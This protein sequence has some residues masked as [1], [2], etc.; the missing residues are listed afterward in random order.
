MKTFDGRDVQPEE[1]EAWYHV[2][3]PV[4]EVAAR[5]RTAH[6]LPVYRPSDP[7]AIDQRPYIEFASRDRTP[8]IQEEQ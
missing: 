3:V 8:A 5:K 1:V 4:D 6:G 2:G 7:R